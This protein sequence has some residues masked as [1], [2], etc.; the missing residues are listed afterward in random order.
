MKSIANKLLRGAMGIALWPSMRIL[1]TP[2][3]R[4]AIEYVVTHALHKAYINGLRDGVYTTTPGGSFT[5]AAGS[6]PY[7]TAN[8]KVGRALV[9]GGVSLEDMARLRRVADKFIDT[10]QAAEGGKSE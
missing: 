1:I 4:G 5:K 6:G 2:T 7:F 3:A 10:L 9:E 8:K